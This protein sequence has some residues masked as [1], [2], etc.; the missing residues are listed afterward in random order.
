M[1]TIYVC[2][3]ALALL[4]TVHLEP[5]MHASNPCHKTC[6]HVYHM[7]TSTLHHHLLISAAGTLRWVWVSACAHSGVASA[8]AAVKHEIWN[9]LWSSGPLI[10]IR[11]DSNVTQQRDLDSFTFISLI[12][13]M[14]PI[15]LLYNS[16]H[17]YNAMYGNII[18]LRLY[19]LPSYMVDY[20]SSWPSV[21]HK[22]IIYQA[23][24][25]KGHVVTILCVECWLMNM[26]GVKSVL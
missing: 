18:I 9:S 15:W 10:I 19:Y 22:Y 23:S 1:H 20:S 24:N 17:H 25:H 2:I 21:V 26:S 5:E 7:H 11:S 3:H 6:R 13:H 4:Y 14:A 12:F 16:V 8:A